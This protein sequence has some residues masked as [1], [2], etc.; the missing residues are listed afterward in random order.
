MSEC[1]RNHENVASSASWDA[2]LRSPGVSLL[3]TV[4]FLGSIVRIK[5]LLVEW[6]T[7]WCA[8]WTRHRIFCA[9]CP[10]SEA[11][12]S[13]LDRWAIAVGIIEVIVSFQ[14]CSFRHR[15][16][17]L[18]IHCLQCRCLPVGAVTGLLAR[19]GWCRSNLRSLLLAPFVPHH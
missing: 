2:S 16:F 12:L 1:F 10:R 4:N 18:A 19:N 7:R 13:P 9:I 5:F 17:R 8:R 11:H 14:E 3:P 15:E 6:S